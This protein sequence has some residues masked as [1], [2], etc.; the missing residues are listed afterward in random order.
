MATTYTPIR[1]P[2]RRLGSITPTEFENLL[3][4][5][6]IQRGM[7]NVA[8]RTP[9]ADGGRDIE[10]QSVQRDFSGT[11]TVQKWFIECKRYT[12]SVDWPTIYGKLAYADS[13]G[14]DFLLICTASK[15]TPTAITHVDQ[16]NI[17]RRGVTIRLWPGHEIESQ[18]KQHP[19]IS[20]KYGLLSAPTAP[21]RSIIS[22]ALALSKSVASHGAEMHFKGLPSDAML[23]ASQAISDLLAK[24]MED[25]NTVGQIRLRF[26]HISPDALEGCQFNG[27][28]LRIDEFGIRAFAAY[29]FAL[30]RTPLTLSSTGHPSCEIECAVAVDS[31]L[32]R[33]RDAFS[34]IAVWSNAEINHA[35]NKIHWKQRQ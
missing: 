33:Y 28:F 27:D 5:L 23:Q 9:G 8:W 20:L 34:S 3:Y 35:G 21:G 31:L 24:R 1:S 22:L 4:D 12:G 29:L 19:D 13:L 16:W 25:L 17:G 2:L 14:A 7:V 32:D 6:V 26:A 15:F 30:I 10:A 18:L 11:Q